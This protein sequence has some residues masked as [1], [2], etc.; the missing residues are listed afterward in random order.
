MRF[1]CGWSSC[2][3]VVRVIV[4]VR[5]RWGREMG[6]CVVDICVLSATQCSVRASISVALKNTC[7]RLIKSTWRFIFYLHTH[8]LDI[9]VRLCQLLA[10][11]LSTSHEIQPS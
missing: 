11:T 9:S 2:E 1:V 10:F 8:H 4:V 3:S 7:R 6:A 5:Y